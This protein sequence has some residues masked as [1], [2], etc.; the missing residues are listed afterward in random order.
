MTLFVLVVFMPLCAVFGGLLAIVEGASFEDGFLHVG[1][2]VVVIALY[3][4]K[5]KSAG[6]IT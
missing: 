3:D 4:I 2:N 5:P 6:G 1:G